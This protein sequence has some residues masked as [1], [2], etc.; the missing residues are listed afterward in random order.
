MNLVKQIPV[1]C[2]K[3]KKLKSWIRTS[4]VSEE[5]AEAEAEE[6]EDSSRLRPRK[7]K[8]ARAKNT[9]AMRK[10]KPKNQFC[11][12]NGKSFWGFAREPLIESLLRLAFSVDDVCFLL[13]ARD[14]VVGGAPDEA[15]VRSEDL[16]RV[17]GESLLMSFGF[18]DQQDCR[19]DLWSK[20]F[21]VER[22]RR[23][24]PVGWLGLNE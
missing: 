20:W 13:W 14:C 19:M 17:H 3:I 2:Y 11:C 18:G 1:K 10:S 16:S 8:T 15:T 21:W 23:W 12:Q 6:G 4:T 9:I 24:W 7:R 22:G 5:A